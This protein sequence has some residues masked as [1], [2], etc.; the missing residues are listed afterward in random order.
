MNRY[1]LEFEKPLQELEDKIDELERLVEGGQVGIEGEIKRMRSRAEKLREDIYTHLTRWQ[2]VQLAR[3][4]QRP[5]TLDYIKLLT[6][7]FIELHGDRNFR[8]DPS[9]VSGLA[10]WGDWRVAIIGQQKGRGTRENLL[11]NFGSPHPEGYR[12]ALRIM[13]L[14]EKFNLPIITLIDTQGAYPGIGA[15]ERGQASAIAENLYWMAQ[16]KVPT[17]A[18]II[19]E[20]GSGGALALAV[21]DRV[22]MLQYAIYSVISPEGCA[23]ILYRDAARAQQ[24]A[25][26]LRLTATDL[27]GFKLIDEIIPEPLGGAH[28]D[29]SWTA[30]QIDKTVRKALTDLSKL[31]TE[32]RIEKRIDKYGKMGRWIEA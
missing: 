30:E 9:I 7:D 17:I 24:A 21:T 12:K 14:A 6:S 1:T 26:A 13:R 31:D 11:R 18:I 23:S 22:Y 25:E 32:D 27:K 2:S 4:P 29:P 28:K 20:G 3:H 16:L 10:R 8:D 5:Y 15:E 19:G